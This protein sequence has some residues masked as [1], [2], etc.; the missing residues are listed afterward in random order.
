MIKASEKVLLDKKISG[1]KI[2]M[3]VI[4]E[5]GRAKLLEIKLDD[6]INCMKMNFNLTPKK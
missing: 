4:E 3:P 6:F 5:I 1:N 2:R